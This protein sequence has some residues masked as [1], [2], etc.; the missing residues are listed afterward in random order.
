[1]V[2]LTDENELFFWGTRRHKAQNDS[3][4]EDSGC[5]EISSNH[6]ALDRTNSISDFIKIGHSKSS[7]MKMVETI[8][9]DFP[10]LQLRDPQVIVDNFSQLMS[11]TSC[12]ES[13]FKEDLIFK[14]QA[15]VALYS[16]QVHLQ[17][18]ETINLTELNCFDDESVFVTLDTSI[19][20]GREHAEIDEDEEEE[21][22]LMSSKQFSMLNLPQLSEYDSSARSS[23]EDLNIT[24]FRRAEPSTL[25]TTV[26]PAWLKQEM[27]DNQAD[28]SRTPIVDRSRA[29]S[30]FKELMFLSLPSNLNKLEKE[31]VK[32]MLELKV[33]ELHKQ[34]VQ[35]EDGLENYKNQNR[36]LQEEVARL[37]RKESNH[38]NYHNL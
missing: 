29:N 25:D 27:K 7:L 34:L 21:N 22:H 6:A 11:L 10:V 33:R 13:E 14:P 37:R 35:A 18:G 31:L 38:S 28:S 4:S 3:D 16:S 26:I 2:A 30:V 15:I 1:M 17:Y 32:T 5:P 9:P 36:E 24:A 20:I 19:S 8:G 12:P 23:R